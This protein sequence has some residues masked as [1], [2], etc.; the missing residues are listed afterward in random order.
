[1]TGRSGS[2]AHPVSALEVYELW[3]DTYAPEPHN[4]LMA[5]EQR[6]VMGLMP[7]VRGRRVLDLACG[8]GRYSRLVAAAQASPVVSLD[9]S[10]AMLRRAA[11]DLRIQASMDRLP[12]AD[13]RFDVVVCGLALGHTPELGCWMREAARV[14]VPGGTLLYSDFHPAA[15]QRGLRRTF[16]DRSE[17]VRTVAHRCH[18]VEAQRAAAAAAGL[19]VEH[20]LELRAGI[21]FVE[22]FDGAEAFYRREHGTPLV[23][24]VR[25][26]KATA[27]DRARSSGDDAA[28]ESATGDGHVTDVD[29][30]EDRSWNHQMAQRPLARPTS[31][32]AGRREPIPGGSGRDIPVA[33]GPP[34]KIPGG[35]FGRGDVGAGPE[36][37]VP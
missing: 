23:L 32:A 33:D 21:E 9:L 26:R 24:V 22:A 17:R 31:S 3:A 37:S 35:F 15:S 8:S 25:A 5:V 18:S 12:F 28:R 20:V 13:A 30:A 16:K 34:R 6:A 1:M 36:A 7:D 11:T 4:P 2:H 29:A 10:P 14:L 19:T 27:A